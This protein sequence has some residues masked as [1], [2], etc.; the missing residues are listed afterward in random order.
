MN[1]HFLALYLRLYSESTLVTK[2][3]HTGNNTLTMVVTNYSSFGLQSDCLLIK[4]NTSF[5]QLFFQQE[6]PGNSQMAEV[7]LELGMLGFT[8]EGLFSGMN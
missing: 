4:I 2:R 7:S 3:D 6:G 8:S 5:K 1:T